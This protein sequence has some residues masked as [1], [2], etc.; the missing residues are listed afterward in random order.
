MELESFFS[1]SD[2]LKKVRQGDNTLG[3]V[4]KLVDFEGIRKNP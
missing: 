1:L 3:M 4:S 2:H